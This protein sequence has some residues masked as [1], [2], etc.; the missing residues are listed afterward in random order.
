MK[1]IILNSLDRNL[2]TTARSACVNLLKNQELNV[3]ITELHKDLALIVKSQKSDSLEEAVNLALIEEQDQLSI[4]E[5]QKYQAITP[6]T[7][8]HCT[9]CNKSGHTEFNCLFKGKTNK[10]NKVEN[11]VRQFQNAN[12]NNYQHNKN[13]FNR[14]QNKSF[15]HNQNKFQQ[16]QGTCCTKCWFP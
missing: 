9:F 14:D 7:R 15:T 11:N 12:H 16:K 4:Y 6:T 2:D 3:F 13:T 5:I 10:S 8:K 1:I